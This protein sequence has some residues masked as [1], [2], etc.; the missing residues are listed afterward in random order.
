MSITVN[1]LGED[2]QLSG[3]PVEIECSGGSAPAGSR[4]YQIVLKIISQDGKLEKFPKVDAITPDSAGKALFDISGYVDQPVNLQFQFPLSGAV[5]SYSTQA[6]NVQVQ[7][8]ET[9]MD[10]DGITQEQ[11]GSVSD[12]FQILKGGLSQMQLNMMRDAGTNFYQ[13]YL[14]NGKWLT[15]R[16]WGDFVHPTQPVKLWF[17]PIAG[18]SATLNSKAVYQ[19]NSE[20]TYTAAVTLSA[21]N[22]YEFNVNPLLLGKP[23]V[24][25]NGSPINF[26]DVWLSA[27]GTDISDRRRFTVDWKYNERPNFLFFANS[28]GGIDD[29]YLSGFI[30]DRFNVEGSTAFKRATRTDTAN[31]PTI[32]VTNKQGKNHWTVNTGY[33]SLP[34]MQYL[35]DLLVSKQAWYVYSNAVGGNHRIVP[36]VVENADLVLADRKEDLYAMEIAFSEAHTSKFTF[37]NRSY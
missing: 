14:A 37:D 7:P 13:F 22:L 16:P 10:E 35:R 30:Q 33:K 25:T 19:D 6:F 4:N 21:D 1:I 20:D 5:K 36:V 32:I 28:L 17:M 8:G 3:N 34:T 23:D 31:D 29:V 24:N 11:W 26:F 9:W 15:A 12:V 18:A 2:V 27:G